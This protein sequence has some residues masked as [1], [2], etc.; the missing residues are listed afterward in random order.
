MGLAL[1]IPG[2]VLLLNGT[3]WFDGENAVGRVLT[4]IGAILL[5]I[6]V[7][8]VLFVGGLAARQL[9]KF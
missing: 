3:T 7:L 6:Q 9:R 4:I 2:L 8:W 5:A 1:L